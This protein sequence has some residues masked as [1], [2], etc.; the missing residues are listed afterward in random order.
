L[1]N[2]ADAWSL[3]DS[4]ELEAAAYASLQQPDDKPTAFGVLDQVSRQLGGHQSHVSR[5][6]IVKIGSTGKT[7]GDSPRLRDI[8]R[9]MDLEQLLFP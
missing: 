4:H 7:S 6:N 3:V 8:A 1:S 2:I 9:V 5:F